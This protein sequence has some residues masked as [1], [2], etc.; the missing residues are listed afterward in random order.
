[1]PPT[2]N[3][4]PQHTIATSGTAGTGSVYIDGILTLV[5]PTSANPGTYTATLTFTAV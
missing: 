2:I 1:M 5:A 3:S 4:T